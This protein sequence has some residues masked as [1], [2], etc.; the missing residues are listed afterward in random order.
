MWVERRFGTRSAGRRRAGITWCVCAVVGPLCARYHVVRYDRRG[1][2]RSESAATVFNPVEDI[3]KVMRQAHMERG[4]VGGCS[5]GGGA[6][7]E[8]AVGDLEMVSGLFLI[9]P[10]VHGVASSDYFDARNTKNS[11]PTDHG[12]LKGAAK[13]WSED[14]FII[15]GNDPASRKKVYDALVANPQDLKVGGEFE[16]RPS[17]P[18]SHRLSEIRVPTLALAGEYDI[19]DVFAYCG[20]IE[21][22]VT[23]GS[24]EVVKD[25]GHLIQIQRPVELVKDFNRFVSLVERK[26]FSLTDSHLREF[27]GEYKVGPR[28][29][30]VSLKDHRLVMEIPGDPYYWLFPS[31]ETK[32]FLRTENTELEFVM[33]GQKVTE[34]IVHNSDGTVNHCPRVDTIAPQ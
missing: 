4:I 25:A 32:F 3:N 30:T 29:G 18:T 8:F 15:G 22:A 31:A 19:A 10:V 17:P 14:R 24:F 5:S 1:Y 13:N 9:G 12:D 26:E 20:V 2:G 11:A 7:V 28:I 33:N 16:I 6:G 23:L 21:A 27:A 34:M